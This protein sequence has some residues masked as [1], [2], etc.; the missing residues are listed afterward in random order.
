MQDVG[1]AAQ[2]V[3]ASRAL[4]A[5]A[6]GDP[7][8]HREYADALDKIIAELEVEDQSGTVSHKQLRRL[9]EQEL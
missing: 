4:A 8:V 9:L 6:G 1:N 7:D 3:P 5:G 2:A